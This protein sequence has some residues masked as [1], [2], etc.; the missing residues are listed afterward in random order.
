MVSLLLGEWLDAIVIVLLVILNAVIGVVQEY[1]AD[2]ALASL[3]TMA[4]PEARVIRSGRNE[5]VPARTLVAGDVV[6]LE[7]GSIVPADMR[8]TEAVNL[9]V[10]ESSLTGE[11]SAVDK[12]AEAA[13][14]DDTP[15]AEQCTMA[16]MGTAVTCGRGRGIVTGTGQGHADRA[17]RPDAGGGR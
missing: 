14:A 2:R 17:H 4:A 10:Q 7:A 5:Q 3:R 1:K 15:L 6:L 9:Q 8:L 13:L 12:H 16:W 11:S